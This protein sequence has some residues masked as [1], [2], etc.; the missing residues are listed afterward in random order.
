[1]QASVL[2]VDFSNMVAFDKLLSV[3]IRCHEYASLLLIYVS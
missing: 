3:I 2:S 1:M